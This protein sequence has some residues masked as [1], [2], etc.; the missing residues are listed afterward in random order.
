MFYQIATGLIYVLYYVFPW[1]SI[2]W[3]MVCTLSW[4]Q[5]DGSWFDHQ[6]SW[7]LLT[8]PIVVM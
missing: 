8:V 6:G 3:K 5:I 7:V 4:V 2:V 1:S